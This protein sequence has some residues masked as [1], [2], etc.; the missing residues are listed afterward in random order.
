MNQN[1]SSR[2]DII[3]EKLRREMAAKGLDALIALTPENAYYSC[4][5]MSYFLYNFRTA[6]LMMTVIPRSESLEPAAIVCD[7]ESQTIEE[8]TWIRDV[9]K[10]PMW[11]DQAVVENRN[12]ILRVLGGRRPF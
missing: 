1:L 11:I 6:G 8:S 2:G 3:L 9:R 7:F 12:P 4:G 5:S 10:Y